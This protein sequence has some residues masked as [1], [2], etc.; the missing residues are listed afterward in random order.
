MLRLQRALITGVSGFAGGF[1]A[2]HLLDRGDEV[3]GCS[4]DGRWEKSSPE[5]L[6]DRVELLPWDVGDPGGMP[7]ETRRRILDFRPDCIYHLAAMSVPDDCGEDEAVPVAT[8]VNVAGTRRVMELAAS[9]DAGPRVLFASSSHVY[10]PV[11][12]ESPQVDE[13]APVGPWRGYGRTKLAA[14][15]E[16][17]RAVRHRGC[18]AVIV[19]S[20]QHTGPRQNPRMMLPEWARQFA[21]GGSEPVQVLNRNARIDLSDGRDVVRAYRLLVERGRSG[22]AYNVGSG[23]SRRSG[24]VLELLRQMADPRREIVELRPGLK[25]DP[26]A[27]VSRLVRC[28]DWRATIGL[29]TTVADTL[30]WWRWFESAPTHREPSQESES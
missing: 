29:E 14:E 20:F 8:A 27:D 9:L 18:D 5:A 12:A 2:E 17:R 30:A 1:L 25:Q 4:L 28:T 15:R 21:T 6:R 7:D 3:L 13:N 19:R 23:I 22:E 10:A 16:V 24:D 11:S 26:I